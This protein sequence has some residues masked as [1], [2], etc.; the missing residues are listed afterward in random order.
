MSA[1]AGLALMGVGFGSP[2]VH[3]KQLLGLLLLC[4]VLAI[5]I[6]IPACGG[7]GNSPPPPANKGTPAGTYTVTIKGEDVNGV[8][9]TN[10]APT[11]TIAVN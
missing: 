11:L 1:I 9:P 7:G 3:K 4:F 8:A 10:A 6:N 5:V 2:T